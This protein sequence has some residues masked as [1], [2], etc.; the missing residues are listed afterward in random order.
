MATW[1]V[2]FMVRD[3]ESTGSITVHEIP[4][5]PDGYNVLGCSDDSANLPVEI[6]DWCVKLLKPYQLRNLLLYLKEACDEL[7][8]E[9]T[10]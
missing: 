4:V 3:Q 1:D 2:S 9:E 5:D 10:E 6:S 8:P 7:P